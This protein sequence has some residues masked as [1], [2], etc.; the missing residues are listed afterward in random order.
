MN[1]YKETILIMRNQNLKKN[2]HVV[3]KLKQNGKK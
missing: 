3:K 2:I 1:R